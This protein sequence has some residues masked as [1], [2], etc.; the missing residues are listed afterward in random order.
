VGGFLPVALSVLKLRKQEEGDGTYGLKGAMKEL[1]RDFT[2]FN[3]NN[4]QWNPTEAVPYLGAIIGGIII[5]K[6]LVKMA[7]RYIK[8]IPFIEI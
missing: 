6:T 2:G 1:V 3:V 5:H 8:N 4:N 7:N